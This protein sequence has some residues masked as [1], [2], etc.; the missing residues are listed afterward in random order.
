MAR[1]PASTMR[2]HLAALGQVLLLASACIP[3]TAF[4]TYWASDSDCFAHPT[5]SK[6]N[7]RAP[8]ADR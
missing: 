2:R 3:C 1:L 6:G 5:A 4:P 8:E 7:H